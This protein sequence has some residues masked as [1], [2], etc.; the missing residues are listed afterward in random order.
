MSFNIDNIELKILNAVSGLVVIVVLAV[1]LTH[2][3]LALAMLSLSMFFIILGFAKEFFLIKTTD[4]RPTK[5]P[6]EVR[7]I[8]RVG[9]SILFFLNIIVVLIFWFPPLLPVG[10]MVTAILVFGGFPMLILYLD[11]ERFGKALAQRKYGFLNRD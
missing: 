9:L 2:Q 3:D 7:R 1:F 10:E 6:I 5:L 11:F 8:N 4:Y